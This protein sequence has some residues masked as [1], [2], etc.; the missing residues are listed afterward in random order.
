MGLLHAPSQSV[1]N[2]RICV[3][4]CLWGMNYLDHIGLLVIGKEN[5]TNGKMI[6]L[7]LNNERYKLKEKHTAEAWI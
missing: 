2:L 1:V 3:F 6:T 7:S 5:I 4:C